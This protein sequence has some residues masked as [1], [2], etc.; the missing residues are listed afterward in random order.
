MK[1]WLSPPK[2]VNSSRFTVK[3]RACGSNHANAVSLGWYLGYILTENMA[4]IT[5]LRAANIALCAAT[6]PSSSSNMTSGWNSSGLE[7]TVSS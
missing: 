2:L 7:I 4:A 1:F 5:S 6:R 3:S